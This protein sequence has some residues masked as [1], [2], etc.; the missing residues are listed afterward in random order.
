MKPGD[1][2]TWE[3]PR[4]G[5]DHV[6]RVRGIH[7]GGVGQESVIEVENVSHAP[8]W[9]ERWMVHQIMWI[10]ECLLRNCKV[11]YDLTDS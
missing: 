4:F 1:L 9:T 7:L 8:A 6:W 3:D 5:H 2:I 10:P 11:T